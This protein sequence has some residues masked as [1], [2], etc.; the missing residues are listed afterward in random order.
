MGHP[1]Q[2]DFENLVCDQ[3][4]LTF[5][6]TYHDV[7]N[8]YKIFGPELVGLRGKIMRKD[9]ARIHPE[10]VEIPRET[11]EQNKMVTLTADIMFVNGI[12]FIVTYV[13][14]MGM[15]TVEWMPNMT[16]NN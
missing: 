9:L 11:I 10:H 4:I 13:R 8:A 7:I 6:I 15:I 3:M 16:K 14:G 12:P 1:S 2:H 5:P